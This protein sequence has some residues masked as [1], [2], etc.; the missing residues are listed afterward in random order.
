MLAIREAV[1]DASG[2]DAHNICVIMEL[3]EAAS[4]ARG[5]RDANLGSVSVENK[6]DLI[7]LRHAIE[8]M[9]VADPRPYGKADRG[10][11]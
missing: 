3:E 11:Y 1:K 5:I 6:S 8:A 10:G 9:P 7:A 2:Q 4:V